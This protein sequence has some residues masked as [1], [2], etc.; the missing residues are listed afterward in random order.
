MIK[1]VSGYLDSNTYILCENKKGFI[2]DAGANLNNLLNYIEESNCEIEGILL[3]HGHI[4]HIISANVLQNY[5]HCPI[6]MHY[7]EVQFLKEPDLNL[8]T[9]TTKNPIII[10]AKHIVPLSDHQKIKFGKN[11]IKVIHTPGHTKGSV[12]YWYKN[13]LFT[14]DTL[15]LGSVGRTDLPTSST[16]SLQKSLVKLLGMVSTKTTVYPGHGKQTSI[17]DEINTNPFLK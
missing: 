5:F 3:T 16:K 15:F 2:I 10:E 13:Q 14:G 12:C 4:D 6:Y 7:D 1:T 17:K 11:Y 8:S 9:Y